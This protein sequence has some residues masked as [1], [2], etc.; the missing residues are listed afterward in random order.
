MQKTD[1]VATRQDAERIEKE[2]SRLKKQSLTTGTVHRPKPEEVAKMYEKA[3]DIYSEIRDFSKAREL[4]RQ[5]QM[6]GFSFSKNDT[7]RIA[8]RIKDVRD[9]MALF[10]NFPRKR[11]IEGGIYAS[12]AI[13][14]L[15]SALTLVSFNITGNAIG[16]IGYNHVSLIGTCLFILGLVFAFLFV[17]NKN[18]K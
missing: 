1:N 16:G 7:D 4:Y 11:K 3:A 18:K 5:A 17:N 10:L 15:I 6:Y 9:N 8:G 12:V 2:A 14:S 13:I